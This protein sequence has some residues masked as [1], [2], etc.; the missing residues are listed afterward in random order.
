M[1]INIQV[2]QA[3]R[4]SYGCTTIDGSYALKILMTIICITSCYH[5]NF[6]FLYKI[7]DISL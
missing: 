7:K 1:H 6:T 2:T 5:P 4:G 3:Q